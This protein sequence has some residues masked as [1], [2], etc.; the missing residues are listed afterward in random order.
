MIANPYE[1]LNFGLSRTQ[2]GS[3]EYQR[4]RRETMRLHRIC[5]GCSGEVELERA[6]LTFC[7]G[8]SETHKL[9]AAA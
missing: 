6:G 5:L 3:R 7:A 9:K 1:R 2:L 8:C 4:R